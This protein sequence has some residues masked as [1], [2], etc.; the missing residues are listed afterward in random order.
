M[1][2]HE[3]LLRVRELAEAQLPA[4]AP[5]FQ[6]RLRFSFIQLY[7]EDPR[8][9]Y[10]VW[11]QR[12]TGHIEVGLHFEAERE[13]SYRWAE[14]LGRRVL[15]L[16]AQLGPDVELEE[17]TRSWTRLHR[18]LPLRALDEELAREVADVLARFVTAMEPILAE[19]GP[20]VSLALGEGERQA[21]A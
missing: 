19:E 3:F 14:A 15:E 7:R 9:H 5:R 13:R 8:V 6:G 4:D 18:T 21:H 2:P 1:R 17:W 12:K 10:E 16:Q 11:L 20:R